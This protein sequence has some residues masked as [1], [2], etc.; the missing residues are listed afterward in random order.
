MK[1]LAHIAQSTVR[2]GM[3]FSR[4]TGA[5][6]MVR[7]MARLVPFVRRVWPV[8]AALFLLVAADIAL[9]LAFAWFLGAMSDAALTGDLA[10]VR[11]LL[12]VGGAL[13]AA[14]IA[15]V[16][17]QT[18]LEAEAVN[19]IKRDLKNEVFRHLLR[20][21]AGYYAKRHSG[22]LV[23]R[24]TTDINN[25]EGA[26][27]SNLIG[28]IQM[29]LMGLTV[30]IY[31]VSVHPQLALACL[32]FGPA[33]MLAVGLFGLKIREN[34][35]KLAERFGRINALLHDVFAGQMIVKA[36]AM[37]K[38]FDERFR[39][40]TDR[41]LKLERREARLLAWLQGSSSFISSAAYVFSLGA[42]AL[43]VAKGTLTVGGLVA[44]VKLVSHLLYPFEGLAR[45]WGGLQKS[46]ASVERLWNI[47]D[48]KPTKASFP[49][50]VPPVPLIRGITL[51][52]VSFAHETGRLVIR[53]LSLFIPA[54]QKVAIIGA[55]GAGKSTLIQ[56]LLGLYKPDAGFIRLD[57][58]RQDA[59][60]P[61]VWRSRFAYVPQEPYLFAGTIRDNIAD[62]RPG[63][64]M[65]E[66]IEAA[67]Q[68][69]ADEFI[70]AL[71]DGYDTWIGERG[72]LLS[73]GQKQR[74]TIARAILRD[75]PIL[76]LDE[77]TSNLDPLAE[78]QVREALDRLMRGRTVLVVAHRESALEGVDRVIV[79]DRGRV[80]E[81]VPAGRLAAAGGMYA[82]HFE[83]R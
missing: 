77:A 53:D 81:D 12:L 40:E 14:D 28:L 54:G 50:Y 43:L 68:A 37:E 11:N 82:R 38:P 27:G 65:E 20:L 2:I 49:A 23:S 1:T 3:T 26:I 22:D 66:I 52:R 42:G 57:D 6:G 10:H 62:G 16:V 70:R 63:A 36:F 64:T 76:L 72:T 51:H 69:N 41:V 56:L 48:E 21:P 29:P 47:L 34:R 9:T 15:T 32:L 73:G 44:F 67:R 46:L 55:N 79:L 61:D 71:P 39:G 31:L 83:R 75:A 4:L 74:I 35:R 33:A 58:L 19:R 25:V 13:I 18:R 17:L 30:F 60:D 78:R 59:A 7:T 80:A 5:G 24:L 45:Q 8:Y